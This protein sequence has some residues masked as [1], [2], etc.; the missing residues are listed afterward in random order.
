[1]ATTTGSSE[2]QME[3]LSMFVHGILTA[4]HVLGI[5]YN[6]KRGKWGD[7]VAHSLAAA[8]D[9]WATDRHAR[10]VRVLRGLK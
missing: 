7:V 8:Y 2:L 3:E 1:M 10:D 6:V 4:F 9:L 5:A